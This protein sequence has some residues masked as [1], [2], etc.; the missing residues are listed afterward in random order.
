MTILWLIS[1]YKIIIFHFLVSNC[2]YKGGNCF[3]VTV[4]VP[5]EAGEMGTQTRELRDFLLEAELDH[6]YNAFKNELKIASVPQIKYV[7]EEDLTSI[8]ES[9]FYVDTLVV[10][11]CSESENNKLS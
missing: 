7:A 11:N 6:Y 2:H 8:G 9:N 3:Y 10:I 1:H 5:P 4:V